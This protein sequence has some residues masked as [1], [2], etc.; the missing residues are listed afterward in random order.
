MTTRI[1][2]HRV[3]ARQPVRLDPRAKY[4][5]DTLTLQQQITKAQTDTFKHI[6]LLLGHIAA[7]RQRVDRLERGRR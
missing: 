7:L 3:S 6:D 5:G 4:A 1:G 2:T